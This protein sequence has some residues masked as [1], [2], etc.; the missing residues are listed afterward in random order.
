MNRVL[1]TEKS[2]L[3]RVEY[4]VWIHFNKPFAQLAQSPLYTRTSTT[5]TP[6]PMSI[7]TSFLQHFFIGGLAIA[8]LATIIEQCSFGVQY[9]S[10]LYAALPTVYFYLFWITHQAQGQKGVF[11]LNI[12]LI[13][14][15]VLFILFIATVHVLNKYGWSYA[16]SLSGGTVLFC[17]LSVLYFKYLLMR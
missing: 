17:V 14:G 7:L 8:A 2:V 13:Y 1:R 11:H 15:S 16:V 9:S 5:K 10:Y 3:K 4:C 12:H 6:F